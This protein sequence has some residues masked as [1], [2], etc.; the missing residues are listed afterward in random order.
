VTPA[1][2]HDSEEAAMTRQDMHLDAMLRHLGA[3]YYDSLNGRA[4][5]AEVRRAV[6]RVASQLGDESVAHGPGP[7]IPGGGC[8]GLAASCTAGC[9]T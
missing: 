7:R 3:A 8:T 9:G 5:R 4:A 1:E 6:A 2:K